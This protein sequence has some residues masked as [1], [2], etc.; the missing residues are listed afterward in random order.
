MLYQDRINSGLESF[1]HSFI[2]FLPPL[3]I[4]K[5]R[6]GLGWVSGDTLGAG[7]GGE[8]DYGCS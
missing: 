3:F 1:I 4:H 2:H 6:L 5:G 7:D 8:T